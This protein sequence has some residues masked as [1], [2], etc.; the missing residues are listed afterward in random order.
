VEIIA[1]Y[2]TALSPLFWKVSSP[3]R[4]RVNTG[5]VK[6]RRCGRKPYF[7]YAPDLDICKL[8]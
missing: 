6:P 7:L 4:D 5:I 2:S 8:F 1:C 3:D